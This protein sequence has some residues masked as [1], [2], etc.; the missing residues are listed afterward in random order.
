MMPLVFLSTLSLLLSITISKPLA[1]DLFDSTESSTLGPFND[2]SNFATTTEEISDD[3]N[4]PNQIQDYTNP[5]ILGSM[6]DSY[7]HI[8]LTDQPQ[9]MTP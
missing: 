8:S 2:P 6:I 9:R 5:F 7:K 1:Q 3:W 4:Q